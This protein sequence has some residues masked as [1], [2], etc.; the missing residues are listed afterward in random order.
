MSAFPHVQLVDLS[1]MQPPVFDF[2]L[3]PVG[4]DLSLVRCPLPLRRVMADLALSARSPVSAP[5]SP[6]KS[7]PLSLP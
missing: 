7:M 4:F 1:F 6:L 5:S 3:K 2:V